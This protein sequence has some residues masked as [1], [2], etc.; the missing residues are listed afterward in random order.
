MTNRAPRDTFDLRQPRSEP[1]NRLIAH[2]AHSDLPSEPT[3]GVEPIA[4]R[5]VLPGTRALAV[6]LNYIADSVIFLMSTIGIIM[7]LTGQLPESSLAYEAS[8]L[9]LLTWLVVFF[10]TG[11]IGADGSQAG[12]I[13]IEGLKRAS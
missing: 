11:W 5:D 3:P 8:K 12:R 13:R 1:L 6:A 4:H 7:R 2:D 10:W 9:A